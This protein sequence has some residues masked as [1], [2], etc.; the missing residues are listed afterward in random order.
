MTGRPPI[1]RVG[2]VRLLSPLGNAPSVASLPE[3]KAAQRETHEILNALRK[4]GKLPDE[5]PLKTAWAALGK[6]TA[7]DARK[8]APALQP[9]PNPR[10]RPSGKAN[11][12]EILAEIGRRVATTGQAV[13]AVAREVLEERGGTGNTQ[14]RNRADYLARKLSGKK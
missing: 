9:V 4:A 2:S 11:D 10:G 7:Y 6:G 5:H 14:L 8:I 12:D 13:R 1:R 3:V